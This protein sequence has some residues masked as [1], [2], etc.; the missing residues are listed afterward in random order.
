VTGGEDLVLALVAGLGAL[1]LAVL[2]VMM[3]LQPYPGAHV[4]VITPAPLPQTSPAVRVRHVARH[5][6]RRRPWAG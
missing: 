4:R 5:A 1:L 3:I 6:R 2:A